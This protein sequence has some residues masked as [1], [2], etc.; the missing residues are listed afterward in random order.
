[1]NDN[2]PTFFEQ[3]VRV[4]VEI[5]GWKY[6]DLAK[7]SGVAASQIGRFMNGSRGL[8]SDGLGRI[9]D[10]LGCTL[11]APTKR[12]EVKTIKQGRPKKPVLRIEIPPD[13]VESSRRTLLAVAGIEEQGG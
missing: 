1:M 9:L 11:S 2:M 10:C 8:S 5:S 12:R 6:A 13:K 7:E 4:A 3:Q